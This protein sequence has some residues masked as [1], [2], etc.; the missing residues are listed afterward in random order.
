[1]I[2]DPTSEIEAT[3]SVVE[4]KSQPTAKQKPDGSAKRLSALDA[5]VLVLRE[6][7]QPLNAKQMVEAMTDKGYWTSPGGKTPHATLFSAI[8]REIAMKGTGSRFAKG[9]RGKFVLAKISDEKRTQ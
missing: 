5:A 8:Q 4:T 3:P 6:L 1:V 7:D 9:D 2:E